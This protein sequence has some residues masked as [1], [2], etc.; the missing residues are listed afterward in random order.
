MST[1]P[2]ELCIGVSDTYNG[3]YETATKWLNA[4]RFYLIVNKPVYNTDKK[5]IAFT[6]SYM[7][8]GFAATWASTFQ[9]LVF[10]S[11]S[12][13]LSLR[14][15][16]DFITKF[17]ESFKHTDIK[18]NAIA[19][20]STIQMVK[21]KKDVFHSSLTDYISSFKNNVALSGITDHNVLIQYF[22]SGIPYALMR[23]VYSMDTPPDTITAWYAK[24]VHFQIQ[25][26]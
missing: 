7:N 25:W 24:A 12:T 20:L 16:E 23:Q 18:G 17:K 13:T 10:A 6:L 19:W 1:K 14:T 3:S 2:T 8:K 22:S 26:E 21:D 15:F 11:A 4:V 5:Q 9:Q